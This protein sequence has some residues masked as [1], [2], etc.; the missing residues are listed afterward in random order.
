MFD[1]T[2]GEQVARASTGGPIYHVALN[3]AGGL[4]LTAGAGTDSRS[5]RIALWDLR[6][7]L[8]FAAATYVPDDGLMTAG[9]SSDGQ[10][11]LTTYR[12]LRS[13]DLATGSVSDSEKTL[14]TNIDEIM[15]ADAAHQAL[16]LGQEVGSM[17]ALVRDLAG[18]SIGPRIDA[19]A[20]AATPDARLIALLMSA[21][22]PGKSSLRLWHARVAESPP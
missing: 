10:L 3:E 14:H 19:S 5:G 1:A 15:T 11:L 22:D 21:G 17:T 20:V 12:G 16:F 4:L 8:G 13:V 9:F 7:A 2:T 6:D 18:L